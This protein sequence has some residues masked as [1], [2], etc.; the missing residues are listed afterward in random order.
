M[1]RYSFCKIS[2]KDKGKFQEP[3]NLLIISLGTLQDSALG[4]LFA[5]LQQL[6]PFLFSSSPHL[7]WHLAIFHP[8]MVILCPLQTHTMTPPSPI[9]PVFLHVSAGFERTGLYTQNSSSLLFLQQVRENY[10]YLTSQPK[11]EVKGFAVINSQIV[12]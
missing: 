9:Q 11:C 3:G 8:L 7:Q 10:S 6:L 1:L 4:M 2:G 12:M 5:Q